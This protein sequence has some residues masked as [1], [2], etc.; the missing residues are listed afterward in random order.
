MLVRVKDRCM[1]CVCVCVCDILDYTAIIYQL[2]DWAPG[3]LLVLSASS[4][5]P[6]VSVFLITTISCFLFTL[7][8]ETRFHACRPTFLC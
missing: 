2:S 5:L 8:K 7:G 4:S 1:W 3:L 6:R